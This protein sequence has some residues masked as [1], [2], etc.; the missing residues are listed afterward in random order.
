MVGDGVDELVLGQQ[1]GIDAVQDP[2]QKDDMAGLAVAVPDLKDYQQSGKGRAQPGGEALER[3][4][5]GQGR[6]P[7]GRGIQFDIGAQGEILL[8]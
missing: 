1:A 8:Q 4:G 5:F 2:G 6:G 3:L 7:C